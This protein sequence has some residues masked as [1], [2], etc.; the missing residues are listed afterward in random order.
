MLRYN[1]IFLL[2]RAFIMLCP[3]DINLIIRIIK[4]VAEFNPPSKGLRLMLKIITI[5]PQDCFPKLQKIAAKR[6]SGF[7]LSPLHQGRNIQV[8]RF[9]I[10]L[11]HEQKDAILSSLEAIVTWYVKKGRNII[12]IKKQVDNATK[13]LLFY[14]AI[15]ALT[16]ADVATLESYL[17]NFVGYYVAHDIEERKSLLFKES[18]AYGHYHNVSLNLFSL[19]Q[20][21]EKLR[22]LNEANLEIVL[23]TLQNKIK[24]FR[25]IIRL[26]ISSYD[27]PAEY[28]ANLWSILKSLKIVFLETGQ[29]T[30]W[31][32]AKDVFLL[33]KPYQDRGMNFMST[34]GQCIPLEEFIY[35]NI[36]FREEHIISKLAWLV[37]EKLNTMNLSIAVPHLDV[38]FYLEEGF[39]EYKL[40]MSSVKSARNRVGSI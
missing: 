18:M 7:H 26:F 19:M 1:Y 4:N 11:I 30:T 31:D 36:S 6:L 27:I 39:I 15:Q 33:L 34:D 13:V 5:N 2:D 32:V 12:L 9:Y 16:L 40:T 14:K 21:L 23:A 38:E 20:H 10:A 3:E 29:I 28:R 25:I 8:E 22:L 17:I 37:K 24:D 35:S